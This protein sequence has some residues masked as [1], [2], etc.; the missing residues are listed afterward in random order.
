MKLLIILM[1]CH[2]V[3]DYVLQNDFIAKTKGKNMWHMISHCITYCTPFA[4]VFGV[5]YKLIL[6]F[7]IHMITDLLK[8]KYNKI[9]YTQDQV[10]HMLSLLIFFI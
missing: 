2:M 6:I 5:N 10:I 4:F 7:I 9:N 1:M 3:G 8:A